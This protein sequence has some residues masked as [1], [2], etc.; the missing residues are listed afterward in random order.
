MDEYSSYYLVRESDL[1]WAPLCFFVLWIIAY[2]KRKKYKGTDLYRY[3]MPAF[4]WRIFFSLVFTFVSQYYFKFADT[5]HYYQGVL[6][7]HRAVNDDLSYLG[8]IYQHLKL[9]SDNR[10]M[11]YFLYD[12]LGITHMYMYEIPNYFVPRFGLPFSLLFGKSYMAI[13]FCMSFFAFGGCWRLFKMF[14]HLYP[15]LHKKMAIATLFLP[16]VLFWGV[17]L[18]KDTICLGALGFFLYAAYNIFILSYKR[19]ISIVILIGTGYLLYYIKPY[20]LICVM[21]A[22]LMWIFLRWR[23]LIPDKT[24]RQVSTVLFASVSIVAGFFLVQNL[25]SSEAAS[26]YSTEKLMESVQAQQNSFTNSEASGSGSNFS[27]AKV[28]DNSP[29]SAVKL[30]L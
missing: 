24:L 19:G 22:F 30:F 16:S 17:G 20:I 7:M 3:F 9:K 28:E 13:S 1:I 14:Y 23:V 5:N 12:A 26:R 15:H 11:N 8:D 18:M 2:N 6:D 21:P 29:L 10:L 4:Y 25:T 27:I